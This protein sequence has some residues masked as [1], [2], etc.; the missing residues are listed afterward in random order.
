M[1]GVIDEMGIQWERCN[2]CGGL[3]MMDDMVYT[4]PTKDEPYGLDLCGVCIEMHDEAPEWFAHM[5]HAMHRMFEQG[6]RIGADNIR[7]LHRIP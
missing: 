6:S 3:V 4:G 7:R 2:G 1:S 5:K